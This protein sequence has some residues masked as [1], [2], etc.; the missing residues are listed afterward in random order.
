M[1][2][3][4]LRVLAA[5]ILREMMTRYGRSAG[6]YIWALIEP[7][8]FIIIF[9]AIFSS[10]AHDPPL[11]ENFPLFFATGVVTF[12]FYRDVQ[13]V[14]SGSF[15]FNK[16]LFTYPQVTVLYAVAARLLLQ[17]LTLFATS[18]II[19]VGIILIFDIRVNVDLGLIL[20]GIFSATLSGLAVGL[21]NCIAFVVWPT[22]Q[23]FFNIFNRPLFLISGVF[24]IPE[25]LPPEIRDII[26]LNP[27]A[28]QIGLVRSGFYATY[29]PD[30]ISYVYL[31]G[32][33]IVVSVAGLAL[34]LKYEGRLTEL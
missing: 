2:F 21:V 19:M 5:L 11:G 22:W 20:L 31:F 25:N 12:A 30:Y 4:G 33:A 23:R 8:A 16:Q 3:V 9:S 26:T 10:I 24:F 15:T 18:T 17:L 34:L 13:E 6:G 29:D 28:H 14:V 27:I 32:S 7:V 1:T